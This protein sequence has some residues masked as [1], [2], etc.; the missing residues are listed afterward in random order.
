MISNCRWR[1]AEACRASHTR[2]QAAAAMQACKHEG[3]QVR[4][5]LQSHPQLLQ[6][7]EGMK[8]MHAAGPVSRLNA[9]SAEQA[10]R[11]RP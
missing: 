10:Q 11:A 9:L 4:C 7:L 2:V 8:W 3:A 6:T 1:S 5:T